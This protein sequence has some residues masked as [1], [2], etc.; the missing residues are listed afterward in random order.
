M[1]AKSPSPLRWI[2]NRSVRRHS[3][4]AVHKPA[5]VLYLQQPPCACDARPPADLRTIVW[6][7]NSL[8][9]LD[10]LSARTPVKG[11]EIMPSSTAGIRSNSQVKVS[12]SPSTAIIH[13]SSTADNFVSTSPNGTSDPRRTPGRRHFLAREIPAKPTPCYIEETEPV[14]LRS[15]WAPPPYRRPP[16]CPPLL[17]RRASTKDQ[18]PPPPHRS[19]RGSRAR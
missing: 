14:R 19:L 17:R 11:T 2:L 8:H 9:R 6:A 12:A 3:N 13:S 7:P 15:L 1:P 5:A 18:P 16:P 10:R 4:K